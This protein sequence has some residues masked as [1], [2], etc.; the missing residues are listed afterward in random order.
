MTATRYFDGDLAQLETETVEA[1]RVL[2]V[3]PTQTTAGQA[4]WTSVAFENPAFE[5]Q[6]TIQRIP[7]LNDMDVL[8][9]RAI[10]RRS[11]RLPS[12]TFPARL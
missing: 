6:T 9:C 5:V 8:F 10:C 12:K 7:A 3:A 2:S 1:T 4:L 11:R